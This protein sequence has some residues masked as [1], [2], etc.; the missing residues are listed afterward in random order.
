[1][2]ELI[3]V[4]LPIYNVSQYLKRCV[5]SVMTQTY[6]NI[7]I[8]LVDDGSTDDSG[9]ICDEYAKV[10]SRIKV[11]H[12]QNGGLSSA[13]NAGIDEAKGEYLTFID[14]DDYVDE[15]YVEFLYTL[16]CEYNVKMSIASHTVVYENGTV[17]KKETG[18]RQCLDAHKVLERILYDEDIDLSAW[19]KMYHKSLFENIRFPVG[20]L[21]EDAATTYQFVYA[22]EKVAIGSESKLY[23]MI[24]NNSI[25]NI[26]FSR[27]KIDLITSTKEMS[28][29]CIEKYP[30]LKK[31]G[32]RRLTYAYMSTL[33]QLANSQVKD[34]EVQKDLMRFIRKNG[35]SVLLDPRSKNRDRLGIV[36]TF[37]GFNCYKMIWNFYRKLSGRI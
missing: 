7:E 23:Y 9:I 10:D 12:K 8:I 36:S 5:D 29:F 37:L 3:S 27:K 30:D 14:S 2:N 1:M 34:I 22:S 20:R 4:I 18:E 11:I 24:R 25:S 26:G 31:A 17:L 35:M 21:F 15:D 13:R 16:V 28:D 33:S 19:A 32:L 6:K